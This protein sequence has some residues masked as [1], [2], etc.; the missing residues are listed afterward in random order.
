MALG[1]AEEVAFI[2]SLGHGGSEVRDS[3]ENT[4]F[5]VGLGE[6]FLVG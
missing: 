5:A 4:C 2:L 3:Y 1:Y 6:M